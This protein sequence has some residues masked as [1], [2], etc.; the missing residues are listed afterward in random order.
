MVV[1]EQTSKGSIFSLEC[2]FLCSIFS[3][4][5]GI[6]STWPAQTM[7][8][9]KHGQQQCDLDFVSLCTVTKQR[10]RGTGVAPTHHAWQRQEMAHWGYAW[11]TG[12]L[13][14]TV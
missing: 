10:S 4:H 6:A 9:H 7:L 5:A 3:T 1:T 14:S 11:R 12:W 13:R 8:Q 2:S